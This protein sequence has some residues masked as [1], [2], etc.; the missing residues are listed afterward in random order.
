MR[1][2]ITPT[3]CYE[4]GAM[5]ESER[6]LDKERSKFVLWKKIRHRAGRR[7]LGILWLLLD[8]I[9]TSLVY[10]FVFLVVRSTPSAQSL[11]IGISMF[12]IFNEAI[13][14][15]VGSVQDFTGGLKSERV[16]TRVLT[17]SNV[18]FRV[19]DSFLQSVGVA[20]IL[21]IGFSAS[22]SGVISYLIICQIL[23]IAADGFG[24]NFSLI[25][26]RTPDL[27]NLINY[28][29]LL[30]FFGSPVLYPMSNMSGLHYTINEYN[31]LSY[32]IELSRYLMDLDSEIMNLDPR[33]GLLLIFGVIAVA[34]RGF[35]K[36]DEV[37][38]RVSSWS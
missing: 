33:L 28:F 4:E 21:L 15:G 26:R 16:R 38:W 36:L 8:P 23:G 20:L 12:R 22:L 17:N 1:T 10:L 29:L 19:L 11:F 2:I 24:Q 9:V 6:S 5:S 32:F 25:V 3:G 37:R 7:K 18:S 31:P 14:S 30:M 27:F 35:L 34:I 13:T